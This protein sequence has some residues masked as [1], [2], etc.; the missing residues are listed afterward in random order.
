MLRLIINAWGVVVDFAQGVADGVIE[1]ARNR[2]NSTDTSSNFF[3]ITIL[4]GVIHLVGEAEKLIS[5]HSKL[6]KG[7]EISQ[8]DQKFHLSRKWILV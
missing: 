8:K 2:T 3:A 4:V 5:I 1:A 7:L 6:F